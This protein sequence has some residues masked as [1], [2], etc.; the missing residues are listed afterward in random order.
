MTSCCEPLQKPLQYLSAVN[1]KTNSNLYHQ[2]QSW[3]QFFKMADVN[4][5]EIHDNLSAI[6][7]EAGRMITAANPN[8]ITTGTKLNCMDHPHDQ[9]L[10]H[11]RNCCN[12]KQTN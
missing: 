12:P 9:P 1:F 6:A 7:F 5:Q 3:N 4:L 2:R 10:L 11:R 8:S